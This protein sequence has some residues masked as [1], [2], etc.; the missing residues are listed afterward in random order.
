MPK[1]VVTR[2]A[3]SPTGMLHIGGART[4]LFNWLF[5][6]A[7]RGTFRLRIEDT[8]R[9]RSTAEATEAIISGLRWLGLDWDG[10]I[11]SQHERKNR[12]V[13]AALTL[14]ETGQAYKCF[15]TP[16]EIEQARSAALKT[17]SKV[18][19]QSPWRDSNPANH[20]DRPFT[21]RLKTPRTGD[22]VVHDAVCGSVSWSNETLDDMIVVRSDCS[23]TYNFAVVVDDRDMGIT[24][25][26]RGDDHLSNSARQ[27]L[28]YKAFGWDVPVF[29]HVPLIFGEDGKKLSK[30]AG[31]PGIQHYKSLGI[32]PEAMRNY[33]ARLGWSHGDDEFFTT[34]QAEEW[35]NLEAL[36]KS[37]ARLDSKKLLNLS[38]LHIE[39]ASDQRLLEE[40]QLAAG[41]KAQDKHEMLAQAIPAMRTGTRTIKDLV[42]K[43]AFVLT[44]RP[45]TVSEE[46][47]RHLDHDG[48]SILLD[49]AEGLRNT[50]WT[51]EGIEPVVKQICDSREMKLGKIA[52]P[53]RA[54]LS[55]S[56][57]SPSIFD[58][59]CILGRVETL[60]RL[61]D[62]ITGG[63]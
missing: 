34:E 7:N 5:A 17:D 49:L 24:H 13:A 30:R 4:A 32:M 31:D 46:A 23:P 35:F 22:T 44:D 50:P 11:V 62:S 15:S 1:D 6:R 8:D 56:T 33:L 61:E 55:G 12:H 43:A 18:L 51:R 28:L 9:A 58:M 42:A 21:I 53:V 63:G 52:G 60:A 25:I 40:L 26:I 27:T 41:S 36:R 10:D 19:F 29:A 3:P 57:V 38:R 47:A 37:P 16:E 54:A 20:P 14:L 48:K 39:A 2:F 45:I 59:M